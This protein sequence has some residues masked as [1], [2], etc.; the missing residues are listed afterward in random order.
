MR[1]RR[2]KKLEATLHSGELTEC[3]QAIEE[4]ARS[5]S[6][7]AL[8][9]LFETAQRDEHLCRESAEAAFATLAERRPRLAL[10]HPNSSIR[11]HAIEVYGRRQSVTAVSE[12]GR[13]LHNDGVEDVRCRVASALGQI[14][15]A[16]CIPELTAAIQDPE[17]TVRSTVLDALHRIPGVASEQAMVEFLADPDWSLRKQACDLLDSSGW[18]PQTQ[19]ERALWAII[20]DRFDEAIRQGQDSVE[21]RVP[22]SVEFRLRCL[23]RV[24]AKWTGAAEDRRSLSRDSAAAIPASRLS[25]RDRL[26]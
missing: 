2:L 20:R 25:S 10:E 24:G 3:E 14:D 11:D 16:S 17:L 21:T 19:R 9:L 8:Q 7:A 18:R 26:D 1:S 4:L 6:P 12:L 13:L 15:D 5:R 22:C 23:L